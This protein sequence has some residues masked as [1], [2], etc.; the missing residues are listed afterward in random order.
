MTH[1]VYL[2]ANPEL[3]PLEAP[4]VQELA[5]ALGASPRWL[6]EAE[7]CELVVAAS[8]RRELLARA[9]AVVGD[10]RIDVC[11]VSVARRPK[12][13]LISDMDST[14]ITTECIDE[15]ADLARVRAEVAAITRRV[16]NGEL[17]FT[18][19]LVARATLLEGLPATAYDEV[20]R[21]RVRLM[22]G[23]ATLVRTMRARGAYTALVS[24]GFVPIA[25]RVQHAVGFDLAVANRLEAVDGRLTGRVLEPIQGPE[26]KLETL[27]QLSAA[28]G[29]GAEDTI[30]VGDGAND[31][32]L[33]SA[34]GLGVAY[35][36]HGHVAKAAQITI[37][38]GNLTALLYLQGIARA[39]FV[40]TRASTDQL[41]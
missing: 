33:L 13:L 29:L 21:E 28:R 27:L 23:A 12:R 9:R 32:P 37:V 24:G 36:A 11:V 2:I 30:A 5:R 10:A 7:A 15:L 22:P 6:A 4:L 34:A 8:D 14:I 3:A 20:C 25:E 40:T 31:L 39:D 16:M 26:T 17:D 38:H 41:L 18:A 19:S 35:R 1:I